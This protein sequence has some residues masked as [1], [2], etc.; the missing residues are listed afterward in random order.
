MGLQNE[1]IFPNPWEGISLGSL[2]SLSSIFTDFRK[3]QRRKEGENLQLF[4]EHNSKAAGF[5]SIP[6]DSQFVF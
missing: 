4:N 1:I 2:P 6:K 5:M 3:G